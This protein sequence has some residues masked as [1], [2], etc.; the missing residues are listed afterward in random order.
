VSLIIGKKTRVKKGEPLCC[1]HAS[2]HETG[3]G[4]R[5]S[6]SVTLAAQ[7]FTRPADL[8]ISSPAFEQ[9][10]TDLLIPFLSLR[11]LQG[12]IFAKKKTKKRS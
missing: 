10:R 3:V 6:E 1:E 9:Q 11:H 4:G 7:H 2:K 8:L 5:G 12:V